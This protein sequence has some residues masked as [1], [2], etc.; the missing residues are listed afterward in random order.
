MP[1][2]KSN[3]ILMEQECEQRKI[4]AIVALSKGFNQSGGR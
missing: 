3:E 1:H 4:K 2:K